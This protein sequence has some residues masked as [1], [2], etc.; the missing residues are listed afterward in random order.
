M[1]IIFDTEE[2]KSEFFKSTLSCPVNLG[3]DNPKDVNC[4]IGGRKCERCWKAAGIKVKVKPQN[5][6]DVI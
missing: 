4:E 5:D 6:D 2:Q 1:K 3:F